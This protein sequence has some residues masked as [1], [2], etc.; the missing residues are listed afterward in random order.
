[1]KITCTRNFLAAALIAPSVAPTAFVRM[2]CARWR[3]SRRRRACEETSEPG[4]KSH[5]RADP[6]QLGLRHRPDALH[7]EHPARHSPLDQQGLESHHPHDP[8]GHLRGGHD[9]R[10]GFHVRLGDIVQSFFFSPK[11][12]VGG[13]ILGFG[14]VLLYP[15]ATGRID[16][17]LEQQPVDRAGQCHGKPARESRA[18]AGAVHT[19]GGRYCAEGPSG[20]P[21]WGVRL[22][23]TPL[24]PAGGKPASAP[25]GKSCAK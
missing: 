5:Q 21:E 20:A 6:E 14:P 18:A 24:F 25:D 11:E 13:W 17:R 7:G 3:A 4:G 8:A 16:L 15:T 22:V 2:R 10:R 19:V 1:M 9:S 12:P 23:I